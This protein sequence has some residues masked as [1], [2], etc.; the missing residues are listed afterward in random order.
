MEQ[1]EIRDL[2][3]RRILQKL[4]DSW[5]SELLGVAAEP[6]T[7]GM[8]G[9]DVYCLRTQPVCFLKFADDDAAEALR[10]EITRTAWLADRGI[11]VAPILRTHDDG[12]AVAMQTQAL[13]GLPA[14]G[15][16]WPK[17]EL[18]PVLGRALAKL[19]ALPVGECPFDESLVVRVAR[20]RQAVA[21][22]EVDASHF[23]SRNRGVTPEAILARLTKDPPQE[24]F[25]VAHG[26]ASLSNMIVASDGAVGFI[27]CGHA[28]RADRYLDLA[29]IAAEIAEYFGRRSVSLFADAYGVRR[30]NAR[31]AAFYSDLYELF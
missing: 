2:L 31:K 5:R 24:D 7:T 14:D 13:V 12:W 3:P 11:G 25:V 30:W 15:C 26:D 6:I 28:G 4:P 8:S 27:D 1:R 10:R 17:T 19:H 21:R 20:A 16:D 9:A 22:G 29:V 18:L 23:D